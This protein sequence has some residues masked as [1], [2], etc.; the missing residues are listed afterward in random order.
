MKLTKEDIKLLLNMGYLKSDIPQIEK[1][2]HIS[3]YKLIDSDY[4]DLVRLSVKESIEV[5]G[6]KTF[7]S[8]IARSAFHWSAC[9]ETDDGK[10]VLFNSSA[11]F[12]H[13]LA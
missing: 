6:R 8:G 5:L 10:Y 11:L 9:R 3:T 2:I 7:L 13:L 4:N 12:R 1:A